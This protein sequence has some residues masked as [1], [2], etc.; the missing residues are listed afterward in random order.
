MSKNW[1]EPA[2]SL[3]KMK[4]RAWNQKYKYFRYISPLISTLQVCCKKW[5]V[6]YKISS[7]REKPHKNPIF[8]LLN[9]WALYYTSCRIDTVKPKL[10][11]KAISTET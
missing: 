2:L 3:Y 10:E 11:Q 5:R 6:K 1:Q 8:H 4:K 7:K 9:Y